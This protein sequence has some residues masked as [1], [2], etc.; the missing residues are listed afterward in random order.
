[1]PFGECF[2][3]VYLNNSTTLKKRDKSPLFYYPIEA[4]ELFLPGHA[5]A[6]ELAK[7]YNTQQTPSLLKKIT[8]S[9]TLYYAVA[10]VLSI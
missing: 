10:V 7:D 9:R 3:G 4:A 8:E 2:T 1:M 6:K 5:T